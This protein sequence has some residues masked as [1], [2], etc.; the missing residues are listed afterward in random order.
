MSL[1]HLTWRSTPKPIISSVSH[2][3]GSVWERGTWTEECDCPA[4]FPVCNFLVVGLR[5][6][7]TDVCGLRSSCRPLPTNRDVLLCV[8]WTGCPLPLFFPLSCVCVCVCRGVGW[9]ESWPC[10]WLVMH[11]GQVWRVE[12]VVEQPLL[13]C[14]CCWPLD[15][16]THSETATKRKSTKICQKRFL[17]GPHVS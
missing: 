5:I 14:D 11:P 7:K 2:W 13:A 10:H 3:S 15:R 6:F 4:V 16:G 12:V 8:K 1:N 9:P 17:Y